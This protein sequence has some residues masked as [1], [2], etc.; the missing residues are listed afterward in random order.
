MN[1]ETIN[2]LASW[3]TIVTGVV[4]LANFIYSLTHGMYGTEI[5]VPEIPAIT[6][7][8]R[9]VALIMLETALAYAFGWLL[10]KT[11]DMGHGVPMIMLW[12]VSMISSWTSLFNIQWLTIGGLPQGYEFL[13]VYTFWFALLS[14]IMAGI[15]IYFIYNHTKQMNL[16]SE[17]PASPWIQGFMFFV[18][19]FIYLYGS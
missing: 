3:V 17:A 5:G 6:L 14:A 10:V 16:E 15:A 13:T 7:P 19:F 18:M 8:F 9:L 4:A 11:E 1:K 12:V 2:H